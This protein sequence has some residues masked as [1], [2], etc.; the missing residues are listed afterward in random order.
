MV[1]TCHSRWVTKVGN[2]MMKVVAQPLPSLISSVIGCLFILWLF[3]LSLIFWLTFERP[4]YNVLRWIDHT[5]KSLGMKFSR[6][7][8]DKV[9]VIFL[10]EGQ[11]Y[12][13]Q[14]FTSQQPTFYHHF[15]FFFCRTLNFIWLFVQYL[16]PQKPFT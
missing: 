13:W 12:N 8:F 3:Y 5:Y 16:F 10:Q 11:N 15:F 14:W 7:V 2:I 1:F 4:T 9:D 6:L